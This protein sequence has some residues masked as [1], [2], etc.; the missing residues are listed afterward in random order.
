[1]RK[2]VQRMAGACA[3][4]GTAGWALAQE[5]PAT[6]QRAGPTRT[7]DTP[8][9]FVA[10]ASR[11]EW[12]KRAQ[13]IREQVLVSCGLWPMPEKAPLNARVFGRLERDGY[14]VEKV[15]LET[16]PG[17]FLCG[18]LYRPLGRGRGPFPAVLNPHGHWTHG[19]LEDTA[20]ASVPARCINFALQGMV[21][22]AYDMV[23]Y[24]DT[25]FAPSASSPGRTSRHAFAGDPTHQ[26]WTLSLMG[27]QTWNSVRALDFLASLPE[28]DTN[29]IG[30]TGASGGG[31][32]TFILGA[33]DDR[34][35]AQAPNVMVSHMMQGGCQ[36]E[37]APGLRVNYFNVEIAASAAPRPQLLVA[38][39]GDWSKDTLEV[40]GPALDKVYRL[41]EAADR[42]RS[43]RLDFGHN[44][45]QASR[46][47]VYGWFG[48]WLRRLPQ[49]TPIQEA[50]YRTEPEM[51]LQVFRDEPPP[52]NAVTAAQLIAFLI[53]TGEERRRALPPINPPLLARFKDL[54]L[55][56]W[57]H[58][59]QVAFVEKGLLVQTGQIMKTPEHT[60]TDL[61]L[62]RVGK[63]DRLPAMHIKPRRDTART[64][65][66]LT[67]PRGRNAF[68]DAG[69]NPT[70]LAG[71][72]ILQGI[73]VL[74]VDVFGTGE[75][76]PGPTGPVRDYFASFFTTYN[77]TDCQERVQDL[78]TACAF[79][80]A[81]TRGRRV[82]LCGQGRAGLWA[83]LAA[84]AADAVAADCDGLNSADDQALLAR[85]LFVPGLRQIGA[86]QGVACLAA[87]DP[88]LLHH[89]GE[90]FATDEIR[91]CYKKMHVP[92]LY[93]E[94]KARLTDEALAE[95]VLKL[96]TL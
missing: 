9:T 66:V 62:G 86:F 1:M 94:E 36:C 42:F 15:T 70:G 48:Q 54:W 38:A 46:E 68:L 67:D 17:F 92:E 19:R 30:C 16:Y 95:W 24:G 80:K 61:V 8:R 18:N 89:T 14:S 69:K 85:D 4:L 31:T 33:I 37:N 20:V 64:I 2:L 78:V 72:L 53:Q 51:A 44:Y 75:T 90:R 47:Q 6:D 3:F 82:I 27:L 23:G 58:T 40:E 60:S 25:Q 63:G 73:P 65:A 34:L 11:E 49:S 56:A 26:L 96:N 88:L 55:P 84:P 32:Q 29:R 13:D 79:A 22:F 21:A 57:K 77:R 81:H 83:L 45:N 12:Q 41:F 91:S 87:T 74:L 50:P 52:T 39:T 35:A 5:L 93:R 10:P 28:V 7:L 43:V 71:R 76:A 59:L